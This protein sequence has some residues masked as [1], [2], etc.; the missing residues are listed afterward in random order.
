MSESVRKVIAGVVTVALAAI[1]LIGVV[2]G[3]PTPQDR[4]QA[5]GSS[6]KCPVC[7]GEAIADSPAE[8]AVVMMEIVAEKVE[9]GL[10]DDQIYEFFRVR[11]GDGILLDPPFE[12]RTLLLWLLPAAALGVGVFMILGRRQKPVAV[13][14]SEPGEDS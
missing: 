10:N 11:Y 14:D 3:D 12:G 5:I 9:E 1:V 8:T 2:I 13:V 6:I 4:V 7:Q